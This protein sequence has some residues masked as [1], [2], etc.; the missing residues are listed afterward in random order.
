MPAEKQQKLSRASKRA[1]DEFDEAAK[2]WG[3]AQDQGY[4]PRL[5][6]SEARYVEARIRLFRRLLK[7]EDERHSNYGREDYP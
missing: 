3:Y 1:L 5:A 7:L 6:N 2:N 4:G